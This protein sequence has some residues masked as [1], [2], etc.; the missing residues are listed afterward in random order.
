MAL[1]SSVHHVFPE[2]AVL[3]DLKLAKLELGRHSLK[4]SMEIPSVRG[5]KEGVFIFQGL[6]HFF[7]F[8]THAAVM[9]TL[10]SRERTG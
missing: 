8:L 6:G 3:D 9:V 1:D 4:Q 2:M 5:R 7:S 10:A